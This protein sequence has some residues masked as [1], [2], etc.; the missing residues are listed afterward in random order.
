MRELKV[1]DTVIT[2]K[3]AT[4]LL[5][6]LRGHSAT[7]LAIEPG[8]PSQTLYMVEFEPGILWDHHYFPLYR[9]EIKG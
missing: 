9:E 1:G 8:Y 3:N 2:K 7:I 4:S 6:R 5:K